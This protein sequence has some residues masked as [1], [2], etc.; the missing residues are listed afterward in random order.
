M[1]LYTHIILVYVLMLVMAVV[2]FQQQH[3]IELNLAASHQL[4][5]KFRENDASQSA[6]IGRIRDQIR[7]F[8]TLLHKTV[9]DD[10]KH[11]ATDKHYWEELRL[12]KDRVRQIEK[13]HA[14]LDKAGYGITRPLEGKKC[15]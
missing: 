11:E 9:A 15:D 10:R 12:I 7:E 2:F 4:E 6:E 14:Y 1:R 5:E 3:H 13:R 8:E